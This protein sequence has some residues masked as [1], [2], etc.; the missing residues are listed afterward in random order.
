M[1]LYGALGLRNPSR[2]MGLAFIPAP[3]FTF[4]AITSFLLGQ[5]GLVFLVTV[6]T[7]GFATIAM[8]KPALAEF[9]IATG[10]SVA[11]DEA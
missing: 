4:F 11:R 2:A 3:F 8:L 1:A 10:R 5:Y 6:A 7:Y 9:D